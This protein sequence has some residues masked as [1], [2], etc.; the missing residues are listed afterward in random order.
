MSKINDYLEYRKYKPEYQNWKNN[1][2]LQTAKKLEY[3]KSNPIDNK[4]K[5]DDIKRAKI[6]LNAVNTMDE[7]SQSRAEDMEVYI[8]GIIKPIADVVVNLSTL[9]AIGW[10]A[11][12]KNAQKALS[13]V[14]QGNFKNARKLIVPLAIFIVP[15]I[16]LSLFTSLWGAKKEIQASRE[17]RADAIKNDLQS[18]K[19]FA[20]LTHEQEA[21]VEKIANTINVSKKEKRK[22]TSATKGFGIVESL[23]TIFKKEN[24]NI[25]QSTL[26]VDLSSKLT[27]EEILEAKKD[28]ELIQTIVEK[29]DITSQ[30]YAENA[31]LITKVAMVLGFAGGGIVS[32]LAGNISRILK[33]PTKYS[34]LIKL[35]TNYVIMFSTAIVAAKIDKQASRVGRFRAKRELLNNPQELYYVDNDKLENINTNIDKTKKANFFQVFIQ[36]IKDNRDY[37]KYV[38]ENNLRDIQLRKAKNQIDITPQQKVRAQQL[39]KNIFNMFNTLDDKSQRYSEATEALGDFASQLVSNFIFAPILLI[40]MLKETAKII[41]TKQDYK[42]FA[43]IKIAS[44]FLIPILMNVIVTKEQKNASRVANMQAIKELDDYRYFANDKKDNNSQKLDTNKIFE[45]FLK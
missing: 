14:I 28:K 30:D 1:R 16:I 12:S 26:K 23:K 44:T 7:Y 21:E 24:D 39:Q 13:E 3:L 2:N 43:W 19:Q 22:S 45:K 32:S 36:L 34:Q 8:Q 15:S 25:A 4:Q 27:Q 9:I 33:V 11:L 17:G 5:D 38:K 29:I 31:E 37:N 35:I 20:L 6:I 10:V 18:E 42:P 40:T 41:E